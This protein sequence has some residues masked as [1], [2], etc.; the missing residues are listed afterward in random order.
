[1]K[2]KLIAEIGFNHLGS[3]VR[4]LSYIDSLIKCNLYGITFQIREPIHQVEKSFNYINFSDFNNIFKIIKDAGINVGIALAD[5]DKIDFF[6][7]LGVDFYKVIRNDINND[8]LCKLLLQTKK[9]IYVSTGLSGMD[10]IANFMERHYSNEHDISLVH[11]QLSYKLADCNL[12]CLETLRNFNVPIS[13]GHHC[14]SITALEL[15]LCFSP[16]A[17][18]FYVKDNSTDDFPDNNH[19]I[20]LNEV[21]PLIS[22]LEKINCA[23]GS[24]L[25]TLKE[26]LIKKQ[27]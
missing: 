25:K 7:S 6:E 5:I 10:S 1:L 16:K 2:S 12:K 11:T 19:A 26:D 17:I 8:S 23:L 15:A 14:D 13:Y 3:T 9:P 24:G 4:A 21:A 18:F 27:Q 20:N 22:H